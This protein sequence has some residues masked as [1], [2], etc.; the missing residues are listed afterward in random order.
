M[1]PEPLGQ[2]VVMARNMPKAIDF[3]KQ[4]VKP[5]TIYVHGKKLNPVP[6]L[7]I[8]AMAAVAGAALGLAKA[9]KKMSKVWN[10][11]E[12]DPAWPWGGFE[13]GE[14][15]P[16]HGLKAKFQYKLDYKK[17][18]LKAN[19]QAKLD[20]KMSEEEQEKA[21]EDWKTAQDAYDWAEKA[22]NE[23]LSEEQVEK[24][25]REYVEEKEPEIN[26]ALAPFTAIIG[27]PFF[28][29]GIVTHIAEGLSAT[30]T[31]GGM[32]TFTG[33]GAD[34]DKLDELSKKFEGLPGPAG[35]SDDDLIDDPSNP[36]DS[37]TQSEYTGPE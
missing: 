12:D 22:Y 27:F 29:V 33:E 10:G 5:T 28:L 25:V 37:P 30:S 26:A 11:D 19:A 18:E 7:G 36:T 9:N 31:L 2:L 21:E 8:I 24:Y 15:V 23:G 4:A 16:A 3:I 32:I 17:A 34:P 6:I 13:S 35:S 20:E 1:I 14:P